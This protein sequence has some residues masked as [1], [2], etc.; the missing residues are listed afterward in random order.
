MDRPFPVASERRIMTL[1]RR[2]MMRGAVAVASA[3]SAAPAL[4][5]RGRAVA[6]PDDPAGM[7]ATLTDAVYIN[8]NEHPVGPGPAALAARPGGGKGARRRCQGMRGVKA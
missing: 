6:L 4:A 1:S 8:S 5:Q 2:M 3:A 7:V